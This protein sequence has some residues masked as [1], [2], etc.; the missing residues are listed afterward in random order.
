MT[1]LNGIKLPAEPPRQTTGK[2]FEV[3]G[4]AFVETGALDRPGHCESGA[5]ILRRGGDAR[6]LVEELS[7]LV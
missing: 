4:T 3:F 1:F 6:A 7:A 2:L 5:R